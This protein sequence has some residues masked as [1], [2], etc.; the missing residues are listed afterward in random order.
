MIM[1]RKIISIETEALHQKALNMAKKFQQSEAD[2]I[3]LFQ[4]IE[5]KK[6]YLELGF[7]R[8]FTYGVEALKLS[9]AHVYNFISVARKSREVP[10]LKEAIQSG[11][12]SV[13]K[14]RKIVSVITPENQ[15]EWLHKAISLP[16]VQLEKEVAALNP[17]EVRENIRAI[18]KD[19]FSMKLGISEEL[20]QQLKKSQRILS[21]KLK[22]PVSLEETLEKLTQEFLEK[23]DPVQKAERVL[24][25]NQ[26]KLTEAESTS[27]N[28]NPSHSTLRPK[29][30]ESQ[31]FPRLRESEQSAIRNLALR[32]KATSMGTV[33]R[34]TKS[35][36]RRIPNSIKHRIIVRDRGLCQYQSAAGNKCQ[37]SFWVDIHHVKPYAIGGKHEVSNLVTLCR[38]HH[39]YIHQN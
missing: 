9:D 4:E 28:I 17:E 29:N 31:Q 33:H 8:L 11:D 12:L 32:S 23:H 19:R 10:Q 24:R 22:T 26:N 2:M 25:K 39:E 3:S 6:I 30:S 34:Q 20:L 37:S 14:A 21:Q 13:S 5:S 7:S 1:K 35:I 36:T 27:V 18:S 16:R 38:N 15:N